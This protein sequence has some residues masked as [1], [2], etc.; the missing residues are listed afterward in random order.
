MRSLTESETVERAQSATKYTLAELVGNEV[1]TWDEDRKRREAYESAGIIVSESRYHP[2]IQGL[3]WDRAMT[4]WKQDMR[5]IPRGAMH[6]D[7]SDRELIFTHSVWPNE[8]DKWEL[9]EH[10]QEGTDSLHDIPHEYVEKAISEVERG[11]VK[12][13]MGTGDE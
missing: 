6:A 1:D 2:D 10:L 11:I 3:L 13:M 9:W 5:R 8:M 7:L 12:K 4:M